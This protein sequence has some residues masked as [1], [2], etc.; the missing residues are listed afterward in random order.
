MYDIE[1]K[2]ARLTVAQ[3]LKCALYIQAVATTATAGERAALDRLANR[4]RIL[5]MEKS[6]PSSIALQ[7]A[8]AVLR[9]GHH[10]RETMQHP[11]VVGQAIELAYLLSA[12]GVT[13]PLNPGSVS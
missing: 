10:L 12:Y 4:F 1:T 11:V 7:T 9:R 5:A 13:A 2:L 3:H 8:T 6:L